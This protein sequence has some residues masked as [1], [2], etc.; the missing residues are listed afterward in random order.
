M[1]TLRHASGQLVVYDDVLPATD[2]DRLFVYLNAIEYTSVHAH[3]WRKVWRLH[4]GSP[5]TSQA[6]WYYPSGSADGPAYPTGTALDLLVSWIA[7]TIPEVEYIVGR[8][9]HDWERFSF[10]PWIYPV[11]SGLSLHQDGVLYTGAFTYFAHRQWRPHWGGHLMVLDPSTRPVN[12]QSREQ[13][14]PPF[15]DDEGEARRVFDPGLAMSVFAKPNRIV[16]LSPTAQHLMTRVDVNAGQ[17]ARVSVA[18]FFHK[19]R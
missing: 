19:P 13:L 2:F 6:S 17:S 14:M 7:E 9:G 16:F 3:T 5:L 10:A 4:D 18:G 12:P 8:A 1:S 11:G 15:L